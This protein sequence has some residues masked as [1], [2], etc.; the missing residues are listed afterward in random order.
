MLKI[1][2]KAVIFVVLIL[3]NFQ[4]FGQFNGKQKLGL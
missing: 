4:N 1:T 2:L 3:S